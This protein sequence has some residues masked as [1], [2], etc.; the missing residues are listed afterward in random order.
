MLRVDSAGPS[1]RVIVLTLSLLLLLP[2]VAWASDDAVGMTSTDHPGTVG[3]SASLVVQQPNGGLVSVGRAS[4]DLDPTGD[5]RLALTRHSTTG[6]LDTSFGTDGRVLLPAQ[7]DDERIRSASALPDSS[8]VVLSSHLGRSGTGLIVHKFRAD[9]RLDEGFGLNGRAAFGFLQDGTLVAAEDGRVH[10]SSTQL[11]PTSDGQLV[12]FGTV[13]TLNSATVSLTQRL[14]LARLNADGTPDLTFGDG[15]VVLAGDFG[16]SFVIPSAAVALAGGGYVASYSTENR[17]HLVRFRADGQI[18]TSYGDGGFLQ[19]VDRPANGVQLVTHG[20]EGHVLASYSVNLDP[21]MVVVQRVGPDGLI[22]TRFGD[23]GRISVSPGGY[24]PRLAVGPY[25]TFVLGSQ[26][27]QE[28]RRYDHRGTELDVYRSPFAPWGVTVLPD[29][30][31]FAAGGTGTIFDGDFALAWFGQAQTPPSPSGFTD[32]G[33]TTHEPGITAA[34]AAGL[35]GGF[36]DGTFRPGESV[37]RGQ[38]ATIMTRA[39]E[40]P[41]AAPDF[42]D[43]DPDQTHAAGIGATAAADI[44]GGFEDGTFRPSGPVTRGQL[45]TIFARALELE[46]G[47]APFQ[48]TDGNTHEDGIGAAAQAGIIMGYDDGT[49]RPGQPVSRGQLATMLTRA[50]DLD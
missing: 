35:V 17:N 37:T 45:A 23:N 44:V 38:L 26:V 12:V 28:I 49:F 11:I 14:F 48:D 34:A 21:P 20:S 39:L 40:L 31:V 18:D 13:T 1:S 33:G 42:P 6:E 43:V 47:P 24:V 19:I 30:R 46:A 9:G 36:V 5:R 7:P 41:E 22:D 32:V 27:T 3:S 25:D 15:G 50:L 16:D 8:I 29:S 2:V 10:N 4:I